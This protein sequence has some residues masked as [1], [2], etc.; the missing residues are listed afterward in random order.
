MEAASI[1]AD[2]LQAAFLIGAALWGLHLYLTNRQD[3]LRVGLEVTPHLIPDWREDGALLVVGVRMVNTSGVLYRHREMTVTIMDARKIAGNGSVR[4]AP[5]G[6]ADPLP[7]VYSDISPDG[8]A[9]EAGRTFVTGQTEITL[10]PD[11]YVDSEVAFVLDPSRIGLMAI[12]VLT[13][14][15]RG[16]WTEDRSLPIRAARWVNAKIFRREVRDEPAWWGTFCFVDPD[17]AVL[18]PIAT[19]MEAT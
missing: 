7:A 14:G 9:I 12:R 11:E 4:L 16:A 8:R 3:Q 1:L 18:P 2:L 5:F 13:M 10:E 17:T 15:Y 19:T 6:Q